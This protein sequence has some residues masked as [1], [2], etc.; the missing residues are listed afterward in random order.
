VAYTQN[1][2]HTYTDAGIYNVSLCVANGYGDDWENKSGYIEALAGD[3][4]AAF[5]YSDPTG[6]SPLTV[7]FTDIST[8]DSI[9]GWNWS[10]GDGDFSLAQ[11]PDH[12][13]TIVGTIQWP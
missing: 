9:T 10:F 12:V 5:T 3:P 4:S 2:T 6:P 11:S 1:P 8:G 13:Y 7:E